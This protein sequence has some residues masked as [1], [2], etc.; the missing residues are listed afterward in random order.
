M[1]DEIGVP[2]QQGVWLCARLEVALRYRR[3]AP[4]LVAVEAGQAARPLGFAERRKG[5]QKAVVS[6]ARDL[7]RCQRLHVVLRER[8]SD[9]TGGKVGSGRHSTPAHCCGHAWRACWAT[10]NRPSV[11]WLA[12]SRVEISRRPPRTRTAA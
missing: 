1:A 3:A 8:G 12:I 5:K 7:R 6:I 10:S 11:T 4:A 2:R 9:A